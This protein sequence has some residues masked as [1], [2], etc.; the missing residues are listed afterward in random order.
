MDWSRTK[1]YLIL[2]L[3]MVNII[4][5][6]SLYNENHNEEVKNYYTVEG[7]H[8]LNT[9]LY[10]YGIKV[11]V[12][13]EYKQISTKTLLVEYKSITR[14][15]YPKLFKDYGSGLDILGDK[16]M[17]LQL[18]LEK[19]IQNQE[20]AMNFAIEF[21]EQYCPN[22]NV[23]IK[24]IEENENEIIITLNP[25]IRGS[26][27]ED[28]RTVF[29]FNKFGGVEI[30]KIQMDIVG[31]Q[32]KLNRQLNS[33]EAII[34]AAPHLPYGS[35]IVDMDLIYYYSS[36]VNQTIFN[37]KTATAMPTWRI[38]TDQGYFHYVMAI[39]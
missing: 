10:R 3:L 16:H 31:E 2:G 22:E 17:V 34:E 35:T 33:V 38:K 20:E 21:L 13:L 19:S 6:C 5:I 9:H 30:E 27:L 23:D 29:T 11:E 12:P 36:N 8:D 25:L 15:T 26:V 28:A 4:L 32:E 18:P 24:N 7:R 14:E 39:E 37:T 1:I